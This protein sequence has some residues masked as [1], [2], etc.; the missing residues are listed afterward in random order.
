[1]KALLMNI[2]FLCAALCVAAPLAH[3][4]ERTAAGALDT[5]M[6]W[7]A[8]KNL[9]DGANTKITA[10]N[11]RIDQIEKCGKKGMLYA[12]G[13]PNVD[14][15]GCK[16]MQD[17]TLR[18]VEG[19]H[20]TALSAPGST[21]GYPINIEPPNCRDIRFSGLASRCTTKGLTCQ[22]PT[23]CRAANDNGNNGGCTYV[24]YTCD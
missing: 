16:A 23:S 8:L 9:V 2:F 21:P 17:T 14:T 11:Y 3:A 10:T 12:P 22:T 7:S 19:I 18:W 6:T 24:G 13:T 1:M 20:G 4:Q 5:Q 15:D